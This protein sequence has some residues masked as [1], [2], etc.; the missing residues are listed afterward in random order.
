M[1]K[2]ASSVCVMVLAGVLVGPL[3]R[4]YDVS[5]RQEWAETVRRTKLDHAAVEAQL[6]RENAYGHAK[7]AQVLECG[8]TRLR[9][10]YPQGWDY[11]CFLYWGTRPGV[12]K[13]INEMKFGAMVDSSRITR[14][15][16]LVPAS[17]P[18]P[19]LNGAQPQR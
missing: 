17:G 2:V 18:E 16:D 1:T 3:W 5:K 13:A 19:S 7:E 6:R 15:S 11:T 8:F 10:G 12:A 14:L 9:P 4:R